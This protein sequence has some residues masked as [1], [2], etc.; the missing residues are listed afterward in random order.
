MTGTETL[1]YAIGACT[2]RHSA[3]G[4]VEGNQATP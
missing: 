3:V 4:L 2:C 1:G